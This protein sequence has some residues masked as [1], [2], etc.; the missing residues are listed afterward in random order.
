[1]AVDGAG[2]LYLCEQPPPVRRVDAAT[3]HVVTLATGT[4]HDRL[5]PVGVALGDAN[6]VYIADA[7]GYVRRLG[8]DGRMDVIAGGGP[9]F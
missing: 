8:P 4:V 2:N 5:N 3:R 6:T 9:G 7:F 1:M